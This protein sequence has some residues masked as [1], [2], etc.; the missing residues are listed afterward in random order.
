MKLICKQCGKEFEL[1]ESEINF[2]KSKNLHIPKRCKECRQENKQKKSGKVQDYRSSDRQNKYQV[3]SNRGNSQ[4]NAINSKLIYAVLI[5]A[6]LLSVGGIVLTHI[7]FTGGYVGTTESVYDRT[8]YVPEEMHREPESVPGAVADESESTI[9]SIH[10]EA[11][12]P[13]E[14]IQNE[15]EADVENVQSEE[16]PSEAVQSNGSDDQEQTSESITPQYKFRNSELLTEHFDKHGREMGFSTKEEYQAAA[17]AVVTNANALHK[18]EAEDGD[19]VYYLEA[20][21]EFVIVSTDGYIR[22]YFK[23]DDGIAYFNRQ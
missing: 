17:S 5:I 22:T 6:I 1:S 20:S 10:D 2:Y 7:D 9:E 21:N 3:L 19:D 13:V 4:K 18:L 8:V 11:E 16:T 23:P 12:I 15:P 14:N